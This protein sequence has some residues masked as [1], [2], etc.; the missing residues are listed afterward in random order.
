[1][2]DY[3][4][5]Y[6]NAN[7]RLPLDTYIYKKHWSYSIIQVNIL[8]QNPKKQKEIF[9]DLEKVRSNQIKK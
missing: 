7:I 6:N 8:K 5:K 3:N 2:L 1:M 4:Y 9:N